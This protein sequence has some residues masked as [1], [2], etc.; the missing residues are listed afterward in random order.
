MGKIYNYVLVLLLL[1]IILGL[2]YNHFWVKNRQLK[3][4]SKDE[5]IKQNNKH[6]TALYINLEHRK[7]RKKNI[8][9]QLKKVG[10]YNYQRFN[11][12]KH[13]RGNVG[14]ATSHLECL[15]IAKK[16]NY[17]HVIIFEDDFE[18]FIGKND[19][20]RLL[21]HLQHFDYDVCM[22]AYNTD[23]INITKTSDPFLNRIKES[24][25]A[26]AY[27]VN[28]NYYDKLI[29]TYKEGLTLLIETGNAPLYMNDM[30]WKKLQ[31]EDK[32]FCYKKRAGK[33]IQSYSDIEKKIV[34]YQV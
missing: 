14:C 30:Y 15:K 28:K 12:I 5:I 27:I 18:F 11:A 8:E 29:E 31:I 17:P 1:F 4:E 6:F 23:Q 9:K 20:H 26:S 19:F 13:E 16:K 21:N 3:N 22:L 7:D 32:W 25:T 24:Q 33:Q 2:I 34:D 10:F